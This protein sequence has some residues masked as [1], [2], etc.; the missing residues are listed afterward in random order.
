[1]A[2]SAIAL[3]PTNA[4]QSSFIG[5]HTFGP[6]GG[7]KVYIQAGLHADEH[8]G[9]LVA[10]Y[11]IGELALLEQ[12]NKLTAQFVVVPFA[13]PIGLRQRTFGKLTGRCDW[14]TGQNFNRGMA[15]DRSLFNDDFY[16]AFTDNATINDQT[17]RTAL[18]DMI[19]Q[20]TPGFEVDAL[21]Q[22]LLQQSIDAHFVIDLHCD[23]VALPHVFYGKHQRQDGQLLAQCLNFPVC[24]E[25]DVTGVV[26]FDATHTQ[27]WVL[28]QHHLTQPVFEQPCFAATVELRGNT[29]VS[30]TLAKQDCQGLLT[31]FAAKNLIKAPTNVV[32]EKTHEAVLTTVGV[33][34]V[35]LIN[36][37]APG[38]V[39][40]HCQLND[41]VN[42]GDLLARIV[43][44]D[45]PMPQQIEVLAPC[46]GLVFS[47][48]NEFYVTP[49]QT[50][51]M[52]AT[53]EQQQKA[54]SQLA[55]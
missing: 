9:L 1:M 51:L 10:Q 45:Q 49:G 48:T 41:T 27:P 21:H 26:A 18:R 16:Q 39:T 8:P 14:H 40:Y 3:P 4:G 32:P 28:A 33:D 20:R 2:Y 42:E 15:I 38:I 52:L 19:E 54:G 47:Q 55:F 31:F 13:N 37:T 30:C 17:M 11:L 25:E 34:Q 22:H 5:V 43:L 24:L 53:Q 46:A 35:K 6:S 7:Q 23:I 36:A 12:Q 50:L 44:L 29:D